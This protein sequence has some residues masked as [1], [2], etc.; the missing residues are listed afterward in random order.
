MTN[1]EPLG[2]KDLERLFLFIYLIPVAG[3]FPSLWTLYRQ[4]GSR[5]QEKVARLALTLALGWV[6]S[7]I[8][9]AFGAQQ[10]TDLLTLRLS[11]VNSL[12]TSGYFLVCIM[13]MVRL[14][15]RKNPR[16]PFISKVAEGIVKKHLSS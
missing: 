12:L 14:W 3:F 11:L 2:E 6:V 16:L 4:Q 15:Q 10:T 8:L 1:R 7:Y 13:L 5:E 9:L